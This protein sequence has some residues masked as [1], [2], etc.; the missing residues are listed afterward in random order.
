MGIKQCINKHRKKNYKFEIPTL[1]LFFE[2]KL[3]EKEKKEI[4]KLAELTSKQEKVP[5]YTFRCHRCKTIFPFSEMG[6]QVVTKTKD[7]KLDVPF[8]CKMCWD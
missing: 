2:L 4:D 1:N 7:N 3:T 5:K 8:L 6:G